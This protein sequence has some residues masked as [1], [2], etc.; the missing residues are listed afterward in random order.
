MKQND[1][2]IRKNLSFR[3]PTCFTSEMF[4]IHDFASDI[5]AFLNDNF[6]GYVEASESVDPFITGYVSVCADYIAYFFKTLVSYCGDL[7]AL[8]L[9][10][11]V[12]EERKIVIRV[13]SSAF[14]SL[15]VDELRD[16]IRAAKNTGFILTSDRNGISLH[17]EY[18]KSASLIL[19]AIHNRS[20]YDRFVEMFFN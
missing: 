18:K 17:R 5:C 12:I 3:K 11:E 4:P 19:R 2:T 10:I 15:T 6:E 20:L 9:H 13:V 7:G 1:F 16:V 14:D 8:R